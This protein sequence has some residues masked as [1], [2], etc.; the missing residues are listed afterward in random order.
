MCHCAGGRGLGIDTATPDGAVY[1][2]A[3]DY[4]S[5]SRACLLGYCSLLGHRIGVTVCI[6]MHIMYSISST[7]CDHT[8][9]SSCALFS[10]D[11]APLNRAFNP[12]NTQTLSTDL[13]INLPKCAQTT[14]MRAQNAL[15]CPLPQA[16]PHV[17]SRLLLTLR[18]HYFCSTAANS[19][20]TCP[21]AQPTATLAPATSNPSISA[22]HWK[23]ATGAG[24][25]LPSAAVLEI[26]SVLPLAATT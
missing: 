26:K 20:S 3:A 25:A 19:C 12:H 4:G 11:L 8:P 14:P 9:S 18:S 10:T 22:A 21:S 17:S 7:H 23:K 1:E 24:S 6:I 5:P 16:L 15:E 13:A 2:Y